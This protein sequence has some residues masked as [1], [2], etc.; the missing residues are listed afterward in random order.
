ML[1]VAACL[2]GANKALQTQV[3][4]L[5]SE[6]QLLQEPVG[7]LHVENAALQT[8]PMEPYSLIHLPEWFDGNCQ[9]F[10]GF[11]KVTFSS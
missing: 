9:R 4:Q 5:A 7:Q 2:Q 6:N 1:E 10:Q 3:V 11:T 8:W